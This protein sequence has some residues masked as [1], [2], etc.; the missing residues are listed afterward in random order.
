MTNSKIAV[1]LLMVV[2]AV[3]LPV[4]PFEWHLFLHIAGAVVFVGNIII[5]G[6]WMY[7]ADRTGDTKIVGFATASLSLADA[8]FTGPGVVLILLNGLAM[9]AERYGGWGSFHEVS[10]ITAALGIFVLSGVIWAAFLIRA[11]SAMTRLA[12]MAVSKETELPDE[13]R[14]HMKTW[15]L[16]GTIATVLPIVSLALMVFKPTLW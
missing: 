11:Q 5:T 7:L 1:I 8:V 15:Y 10:W 2:V 13:F 16:W 9:A 3:S 4:Y 12:T 6:A 14:V